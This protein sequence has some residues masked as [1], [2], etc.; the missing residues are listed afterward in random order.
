MTLEGNRIAGGAGPGILIRDGGDP[1]VRGNRLEGTGLVVSAGGR[2]TIT[3]NSI[4]DAAGA[5]LVVRGG[6]D[7]SLG[8]NVIEGGGGVVFAEGASGS[9]IGNRLL[10]SAATGDPGHDRRQSPDHRQHDRG[11]QGGRDLRL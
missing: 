2:G 11:G 4:V 8:D 5:S 3:G 10:A 6:A 7:P 1:V 9:F